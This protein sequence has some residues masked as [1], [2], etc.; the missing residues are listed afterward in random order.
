MDAT[1]YLLEM[2]SFRILFCL[3]LHSELFSRQ[4]GVSPTHIEFSFND[5]SPSSL[6]SIPARLFP[7]YGTGDEQQI[8]LCREL[9]E[10]TKQIRTLNNELPLKINNIVGIDETFRYTNVFPPLP[11][12]FQTDLHKIRSIEHDTYALIP[13]STS[14]Y[15][16]PYSQSLLI[17]C[18]LEMNSSNDPGF[19]TLERIKHSKILYYIQLS[20]LLKEKFRYT[21]RATT[22][23]CYIEKNHYIYRIV[24]SYHKEIYLIESEAGKKGGLARTIKQ[25]NQSKNLRYLTEYLPKINAAIYGYK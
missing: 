17:L 25:T 20:K 8:Y 1:R 21:T 10:L 7:S 9:I 3:Y 12:S 6:L 2:Y 13:R 11:A 15:A 14:R 19:E 23:C 16:P 4:A 5:Q 24:V 18:Q 22:D